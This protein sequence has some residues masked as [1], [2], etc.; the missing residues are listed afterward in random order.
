MYPRLE[1]ARSTAFATR[2]VAN[3]LR[4]IVVLPPCIVEFKYLFCFFFSE[5]KLY[6]FHKMSRKK[7]N[8]ELVVHLI[9][10]FFYRSYEWKTFFISHRLDAFN[11]SF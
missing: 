6:F 8:P 2:G 9:T 1:T 5:T 10:F 3:P 7:S 11:S 4:I